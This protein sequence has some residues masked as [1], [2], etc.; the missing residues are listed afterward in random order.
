MWELDYKESWVLRNWCLWAVVLEK[1]LESPLDCREIK[2]SLEGLMLKLQ[3]QYFD[4]LIW[5]TD[6][7]EKTLMLGKTE[8]RRGRGWQDEMVGWHHQLNEHEFQQAPRVGDGQ[9]SLECCS[10]WGCKESD[11]S[12]WWN[13]TE[14]NCLLSLKMGKTLTWFLL[15][16]TKGFSKW[17]LTYF[18]LFCS[19]PHPFHLLSSGEWGWSPPLLT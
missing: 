1:T 17:L 2:Y 18:S 8:G 13:W 3:L 9:G 5:R 10:P 14:L 19:G 11:M 7:L 4:P 12:E 15:S 16:D 6:S